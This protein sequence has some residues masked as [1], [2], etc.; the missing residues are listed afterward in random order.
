MNK[1]LKSVFRPPLEP[2]PDTYGQLGDYALHNRIEHLGILQIA[3]R[4]AI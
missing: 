4:I 3:E 1:Y 2:P